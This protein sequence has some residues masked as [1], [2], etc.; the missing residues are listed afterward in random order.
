[1]CTL[2]VYDSEN[3]AYIVYTCMYM[4][5]CVCVRVHQTR[6]ARRTYATRGTRTPLSLS[7][8]S[9]TSEWLSSA[10]PKRRSLTG[11]SSTTM[12]RPLHHPSCRITPP[13]PPPPPL[14]PPPPPPPPP[15]SDPPLPLCQQT[16]ARFEL[17]RE[18]GYYLI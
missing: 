15:P 9:R 2:D 16:G 8:W 1:M 5:V 4:Y 12:V 17:Q 13:P 6:T 14:P 7:T 18:I 10:S 11:H 3:V